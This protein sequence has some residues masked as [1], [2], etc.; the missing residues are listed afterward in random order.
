[1]AGGRAGG[2]R[3]APGGP[4]A[5]GGAGGRP[6]RRPADLG[7]FV[8]RL[9][10]ARSAAQ[11]ALV[12]IDDA[13]WLDPA[14][15]EVVRELATAVRGTR[16]LLLTNFRP[17]YRPAWTGGAHYHPPAP[18]PPR[19]PAPPAPPGAPP[20]APGARR[21]PGRPTLEGTPRP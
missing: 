4:G 6:A 15:H 13:H 9:L 1:P 12:L 5:G 19:A 16:T 3:R 18:S 21:R 8:R 17:E 7:G 2:V 14:S 11:P 20:G 10:R